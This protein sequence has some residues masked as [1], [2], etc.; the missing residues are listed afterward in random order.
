[1]ILTFWSS[2]DGDDDDDEEEEEEEEEEFRTDL[3]ARRDI[4]NGDSHVDDDDDNGMTLREIWD[5]I[6]VVVV[7][8]LVVIVIL[9]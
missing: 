1:M 9:I 8:D 3:V 6:F 2:D 4:G 7:I 5:S